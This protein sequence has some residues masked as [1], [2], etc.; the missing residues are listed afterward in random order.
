MEGGAPTSPGASADD[1][2]TAGAADIVRRVEPLYPLASR[3]RKEEGEVVVVAT[4]DIRGAVVAAEVEV[5]SSFSLL[6]E[7]ARK[8]LTQW[9]FRPG[10][11]P[12]VRVA[13]RFLL[14]ND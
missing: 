3:R 1:V 2:V 14:R 6:D 8:A 11:G 4:L 13:V 10:L 5:S 12:K 9:R 7:S